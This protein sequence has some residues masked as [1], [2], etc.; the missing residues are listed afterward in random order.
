MRQVNFQRSGPGVCSICV[1]SSQQD[2]YLLTLNL[3]SKLICEKDRKGQK[4][5]ERT[6]IACDSVTIAFQQSPSDKRWLPCGNGAHALSIQKTFRILRVAQESGKTLPMIVVLIASKI[7]NYHNYLLWGAC[8][9]TQT[10]YD[11]FQNTNMI[12]SKHKMICKI[13]VE[14]G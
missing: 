7:I 9:Q 13:A 3:Y 8:F 11:P 12:C 6:K 14:I 5:N 4:R 1:K 2:L 10:N